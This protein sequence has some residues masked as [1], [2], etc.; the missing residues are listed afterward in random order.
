MLNLIDGNN[1]MLRAMTT[2]ALPG[3]KPMKLRMRYETSKA[4]DIWV[5]DGYNHNERRK[6]LFPAYKGQRQPLAEDLFSQINLFKELLT[7]SC[8]TQITVEGWEADDVIATMAKRAQGPVTIHS[9]DLD[10]AQLA[11][12]PHIV[13]NGVK[14]PKFDPE[15][16][17]LY[18]CLRGDSSDNIPGI[19]GFGPKAWDNIASHRDEVLAAIVSG[20]IPQAP[21]TEKVLNWLRTPGNITLLQ[22]MLAIVHFWTVPDDEIVAGITKPI[23]DQT[24][25]HALLNRYFL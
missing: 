10:Y 25:A 20:I 18:K 19:P 17:P 15:W 16:V 21:F 13:L 11:V 12:F 22:N 2:T 23:Y 1:V 9:N 5:W 4:E 3:E 8:S 14:M 6:A 7:H 24:K